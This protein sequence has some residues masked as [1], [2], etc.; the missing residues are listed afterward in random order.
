M[1]LFLLHRRKRARKALSSAAPYLKVLSRLEGLP[2][3]NN[4]MFY[5][6]ERGLC[7]VE[8]VL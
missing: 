3:I 2:C 5:L 8:V 4:K 7:V 6:I 1:I